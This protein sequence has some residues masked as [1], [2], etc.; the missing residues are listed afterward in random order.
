VLLTT[1]PFDDEVFASLEYISEIKDVGINYIRQFG[2]SHPKEV[3]LLF[4]AFVRQAKTFYESATQLNYRASALIYYYSFLNLA[5]AYICLSDPLLV[6]SR[7]MHGLKHAFKPG[8]LSTQYVVVE[9]NGVFKK[10]YELITGSKIPSQTQINIARILGYCTDI[11]H[12]YTSAGYGNRR[13]TPAGIRL[14]SNASQKISWPMLAVQDFEILSF[15]KKALKE[16]NRYFEQ[17]EPNK[18]IVREVFGLYAESL[19]G[20]SFFESSK[21]YSWMQGDLIPVGQMKKDCFS[22]LDK[23]YE[24]NVYNDERTIL[25]N[26]P[27]RKN[28]QISF[29]Q[30]LSI[31]ATMFYLGS[32]VRYRPDYLEKLLDSRDAWI[33]ERFTY[34]APSTFLRSMVNLI[35]QQDYIYISR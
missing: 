24:S 19:K 22:A 21:T 9:N 23:F 17:I 26:A 3:F 18:T 16:F 28:L 11:V 32:L 1:R 31:Y 27:L 25:L 10:L 12:E 33:I 2:H 14:L 7:V 30:L 5:K 29:N 35:L 15:Y 4:Q 8:K 6:S 13:I 34:S 20:Y